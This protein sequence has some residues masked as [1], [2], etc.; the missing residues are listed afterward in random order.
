MKKII[1][2]SIVLAILTA[3]LVPATASADT[4]IKGNQD[5]CNGNVNKYAIIVG[6]SNYPEPLNVLQG[7]LD[8]FYAAKDAYAMRT[9]LID[10][11]FKPENILMLTDRQATDKNIM[12]QIYKVRD[13]AGPHDEVV[14]YFSGHSVIPDAPPSDPVA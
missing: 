14:F 5:D 8:L 10:H 3:L 2:I 11:G 9:A 13:E 12:D 7:G 4:G 6:I 1:V